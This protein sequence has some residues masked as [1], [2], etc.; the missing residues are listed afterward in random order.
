[1]LKTGPAKKVIVYVSED[2]HYHG[3][4]RY[5][6]ILDFLFYRGI[7]GT[8]VSRGIAGFGADHHIHTNRLV[9][10]TQNLPIKVEFIES[11]EKVE[12][13]LPKLYELAGSGLIEVHDTTIVKP[14]SAKAKSPPQPAPPLKLEG[15][16]KLM[17]I[18]VG[19]KDR[20]RDKP[21]Y[22]AI[23]EALRANDMA[24]VT[25]YA[26]ILGYGAHKLMHRDRKILSHDRP[27]MLAVVDS[28][29]KLRGF[30]PILDQMVQQGLV[31]MSDVDI[32]KYSHDIREQ[33]RRRMPEE[34][35][36]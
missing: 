9:D 29:E 33:E 11:P 14:A 1:M 24:G 2:Q 26:G 28:E 12:E 23:V 30:T 21:L 18:Y 13:V 4:S 31:V 19:E 35:R 3:N 7:A 17:R 20:W 6:A 27:I 16:A 15:K 34:L 22:Q 25:V 5:A 32:I 36:K 10:L 8:T